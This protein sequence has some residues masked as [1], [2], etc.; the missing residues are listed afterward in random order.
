MRR[1]SARPRPLPP[2]PSLRACV[3]TP[4][5]GSCPRYPAQAVHEQKAALARRLTARLAGAYDSFDDEAAHLP[6]PEKTVHALLPPAGKRALPPPRYASP[7]PPPGM[8]VRQAS[9]TSSV[10]ARPPVEM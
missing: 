7:A 3:P 8:H 1:S 2:A 9:G 5:C 10:F 6:P 4:Q